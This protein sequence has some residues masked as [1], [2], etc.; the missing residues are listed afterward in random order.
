MTEQDRN[1]KIALYKG[2]LNEYTFERNF[3]RLCTSS[4]VWKNN[5]TKW[6][7]S[8]R[9]MIDVMKDVPGFD[10]HLERMH[11]N[12]YLL[13]DKTDLDDDAFYK[14]MMSLFNYRLDN[15]KAYKVNAFDYDFNAEFQDVILLILEDQDGKEKL[16]LFTV[17]HCAA[18]DDQM[19][20]IVPKEKEYI[21][22]R[23]KY[24]NETD[25]RNK[26]IYV[27]LDFDNLTDIH[28]CND[29]FNINMKNDFL[30]TP[31]ISVCEHE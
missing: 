2:I 23:N 4:T 31:Y 30:H 28:I 10:A 11:Y 18:F 9:E 16:I 3:R 1:R 6:I 15:A 19:H 24:G 27:R 22:Y 13:K 8:F 5:L 29:Y 14:E 12:L 25:I 7:S 17:G 26:N 20:T 21:L